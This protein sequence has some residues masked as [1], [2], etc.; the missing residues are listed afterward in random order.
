MPAIAGTV[1]ITSVPDEDHLL[2]PLT[3]A[4]G[5]TLPQGVKILVGAFPGMSDDEVLDAAAAGGLESITSAFVPFGEA[6]AIGEGVD[7]AAGNF[8]I[9]VSQEIRPEV[10]VLPGEEV[11]LLVRLGDG[12]EF[13]VAR[14]GGVVFDADSATGLDPLLALHFAESKIIVGNRNGISRVATSEAPARGSYQSWIDGFPEIADPAKRLPEADADGDGRSNFLEYATGGNPVSATDAAACQIYPAKENGFW[15]RFAREP[16]I[17]FLRY[18]LETSVDMENFWEELDAIPEVDPDAPEFG[19]GRWMRV[20]VPSSPA[21]RGFFR[22]KVEGGE[23][24][25]PSER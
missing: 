14:F 11:S 16:G 13:L 1:V 22:L 25:V 17:G 4:N 2:Q 7:G 23:T 19:T 18:Q 21:T 15:V 12:Q 9:S 3:S 20:R 8:E 6:S 5:V 10:S 24:V